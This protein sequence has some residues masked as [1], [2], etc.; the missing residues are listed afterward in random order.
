MCDLNT[1]LKKSFAHWIIHCT[2]RACFFS[3]FWRFCLMKGLQVWTSFNVIIV[4]CHALT[5]WISVLAFGWL[6]FM[7]SKFLLVIKRSRL[8]YVL[9]I[10]NRTCDALRELLFISEMNSTEKTAILRR[11]IAFILSDDLLFYSLSFHPFSHSSV[12]ISWIAFEFYA[13]E[14]DLGT[15]YPRINLSAHQKN[16]LHERELL[17]LQ[18]TQLRGMHT[19]INSKNCFHA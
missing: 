10:V 6:G 13:Y 1:F 11:W 17:S 2:V 14:L 16:R 15:F 8:L 12:Q 7:Q 5:N 9:Y 18:F 4:H 19:T 3:R